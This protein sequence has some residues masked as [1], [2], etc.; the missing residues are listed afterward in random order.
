M[1]NI[2]IKSVDFCNFRSR[3]GR[4]ENLGNVVTI[5]GRNKSGKSTI[6]NAILWLL[7]GADDAD[8]TNFELFDNTI[9]FT[10]ENAIT[11]D[12]KATFDIDGKLLELRRTAT[13][14]WVRERGK[15]EMSKAA[16]DDYKFYVDG[17]ETSS[18]NYSKTVEEN[19]AMPSILKLILN[20][21]L[22]MALDWRELR[23]RFESIV[24]QITVDE[25]GDRYAEIIEEVNEKGAAKVKSDIHTLLTNKNTNSLGLRPRKDGVDASIDALKST[26]PDITAIE[27][28][29]ST[30]QMLQAE[31]KEILNHILGLKD[32]NSGLLDKYKDEEERLSALRLKYIELE[33]AYNKQ[34]EDTLAECQRKIQDA[35]ANNRIV[36]NEK[37]VL[38]ETLESL[39]TILQSK[40]NERT[41]KLA[42]LSEIANRKFTG[43]C[44]HCGNAYIGSMRLEKRDGFDI[45]KKKDHT[46]C[47]AE[48]RLIKAKIS[49]LETAIANTETELNAL[50][51][52]DVTPLQIELNNHKKQFV[53]FSVT[54]E[55]KQ[56]NEET[57]RITENRTVIPTNPI[58]ET[59]QIRNGEI[60]VELKRLYEISALRSSYNQTMEKIETLSLRRKELIEEIVPLEKK[61]DLVAE[62]EQERADIIR[63]RMKA[64]LPDNIEVQMEKRKKDGSFEP[65][66]LIFINGCNA[67]V[68]NTESRIKV[69]Q[70]ISEA[71]QQANGLN[72]FM[73]FD[74]SDLLDSSNLPKVKGQLLRTIVSDSDLIVESN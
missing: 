20:Q 2:S 45:Q 26:L 53:S 8:R 37:K 49:E 18:S 28:A 29:E 3:S 38:K 6:F 62:L 73:L 21:R 40:Q 34:Y 1:K 14:K 31:H 56:I 9:D 35:Y 23:K 32:E 70:A 5:K 36:E 50:H 30:I 22:W 52:V 65:S 42:L 11:A 33:S 19:F 68:A 47:V 15:S 66:C 17:I 51:V 58:V 64:L 61:E 10:P 74:D 63:Q 43:L 27:E 67:L 13:Q 60:E 25:L 71:F 57:E 7:T 48:G 55:A 12:V 59:L 69:G 46:E 44:P 39:N 41:S 72:M 16:T 24:G 54:D 4:Y